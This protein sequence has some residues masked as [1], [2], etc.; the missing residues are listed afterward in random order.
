M[1]DTI[2][3][4]AEEAVALARQFK[5][6]GN[7]KWEPLTADEIKAIRNNLGLSQAEFSERY[8][9]D[10]GSL[11]NWEQGRCLPGRNA[12]IMLEITRHA[13]KELDALICKVRAEILNE[14]LE[15]A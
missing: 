6:G 15:L 7:P 9:F 4:A 2:L 11:R 10:L 1:T 8:G 5:K 3:Q 13:P 14:E 12:T